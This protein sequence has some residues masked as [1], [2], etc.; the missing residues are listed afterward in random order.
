M[1]R[2]NVTLAIWT[3]EAS[4][5]PDVVAC[6][7]IVVTPVVVMLPVLVRLRVTVPAAFALEAADDGSVDRTSVS[8]N[9]MNGAAAVSAGPA[10]ESLAVCDGSI[11]RAKSMYVPAASSP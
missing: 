7:E 3:A 6:R 2:G 4:R 10:A 8:A 1:R 11:S 9:A 5:T